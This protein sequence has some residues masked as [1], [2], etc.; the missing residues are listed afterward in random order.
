MPCRESQN[1][2]T[3]AIVD[4]RAV[5]IRPRT[6]AGCDRSGYRLRNQPRGIDQVSAVA[7]DPHPLEIGPD[8]GPQATP[9]PV[10][11]EAALPELVS[12]CFELVGA[13]R[14]ARNEPSSRD[15]VSAT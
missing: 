13:T 7:E 6:L 4:A 3:L 15:R 5:A 1:R 8:L 2:G 12:R 9:K 10:S 14:A 11:T